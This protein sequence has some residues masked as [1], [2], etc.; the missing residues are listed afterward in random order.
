LTQVQY[1]V[2][3]LYEEMA[4]LAYYLHWS[5]D[6]LMQLEHRER[7]RWCEEISRINK[8]LSGKSQNI[9]ELR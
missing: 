5:T 9:F 2:D 4:F 8:N 1:P 3:R 6:D 7:R